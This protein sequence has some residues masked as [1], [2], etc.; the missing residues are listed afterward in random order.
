MV[1]V[2]VAYDEDC[3]ACRWAAERLRRW[4]RAGRLG[5]AAI[6]LSDALLA[7]VEA[8]RRLDAMHAVTTDGRVYSGGAAVP[9][10]LR[11]LPGGRPLAVLAA[12]APG[13]TDAAYAAIVARRTQIGRLLGQDACAVDPARHPTVP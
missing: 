11:A 1:A 7:P 5:F 4:D 8:G 9:L 2:T 3:G 6:Q 13:L 10:I 12:S